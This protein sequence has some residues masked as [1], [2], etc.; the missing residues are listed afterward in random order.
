VNEAWIRTNKEKK[1]RTDFPVSSSESSR[2]IWGS[3][4]YTSCLGDVGTVT[5]PREQLQGFIGFERRYGSWQPVGAERGATQLWGNAHSYSRSAWGPCLPRSSNVLLC[6]SLSIWFCQ[7]LQSSHERAVNQP[8]QPHP[9]EIT[10]S[11]AFG[12]CGGVHESTDTF[13]LL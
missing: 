3:I 11:L 8:L 6:S 1:K 5:C 4:G 7:L 12:T 10:L 2:V 13:Q 9:T